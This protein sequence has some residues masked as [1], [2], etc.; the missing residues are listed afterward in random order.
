MKSNETAPK[1][2]DTEQSGPP[3]FAT[4]QS[5]YALLVLVLSVLVAL[6][7]VLTRYYS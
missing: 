1:N 6:F 3:L 4:W 7:Y 5:W 2:N